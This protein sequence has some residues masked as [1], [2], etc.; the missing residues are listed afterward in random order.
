RFAR[1]LLY[2]IWPSRTD[3]IEQMFAELQTDER[4][5]F[6]LREILQTR[7]D[8]IRHVPQPLGGDLW[9]T[10]L[11][12]HARYRR[13]EILAAL[14]HARPSRVPGNFREGVLWAEEWNTDAF[15]VTL[16]KSESEFAPSTMYEDYAI[17]PTLFHWES[18]STTTAA[19]PTGRRYINQQEGGSHVLLF[20]RD[21]KNW[22]FGTGAPYTLLGTA[23]YVRHE[24]EAPIAIT[25][26]LDHPIP[27]DHYQVAA[28]VQVS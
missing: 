26:K 21:R 16:N 3:P 27:T 17:S 1:M 11:F 12:A 4:L 18:Q 7:A 22:E 9:R 13:E 28:A 20:S 19:S 10:G 23:H 14:D 15:F 25:Y 2:S 8:E 6:E 24:G 5:R